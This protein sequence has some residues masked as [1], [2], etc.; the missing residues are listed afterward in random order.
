MYEEQ[1]DP[2]ADDAPAPEGTLDGPGLTSMDVI[3]AK[4]AAA[5]AAAMEADEGTGDDLDLGL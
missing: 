4:N 2:F 3:R 1:A 5:Q